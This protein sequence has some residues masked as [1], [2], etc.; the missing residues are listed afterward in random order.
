MSSLYPFFIHLIRFSSVRLN[1][2]INKHTFQSLIKIEI[3]CWKWAKRRHCSSISSIQ[4]SNPLS[5][6]DLPYGIQVTRVWILSNLI[7][8]LTPFF[9]H[10][11]RDEKN[12]SDSL[13]KHTAGKI[14]HEWM[15]LEIR[16]FHCVPL[17]KFV[18]PKV[19]PSSW[20]GAKKWYWEPSIEA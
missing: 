8:D 19:K 7:L 6:L 20:D 14:W 1:V 11:Y 9:D 2:I 17:E 3:K 18:T 16:K 4:P 5:C 13:S 15:L 12:T 10:I